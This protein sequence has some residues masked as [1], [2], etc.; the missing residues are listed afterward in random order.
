MSKKNLQSIKRQLREKYRKKHLS[1]TMIDRMYAHQKIAGHLYKL[2]EYRRNNTVLLYVSKSI[3]VD[4]Y[5]LIEKALKDGKTVAVPRCM[6]GTRNMAFYCI[7]SLNDLEK[8]NF[9][10]YEPKV[11]ICVPL[12]DMKQGLCIVP[13]MVFDI[14]G[15]RLGYGKGY[16]DR[17]LSVFQGNVVGLCYSNCICWQLPR[18]IYDKSVDILVT[19][20]FVWNTTKIP[21][22]KRG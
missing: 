10:V 3:E 17:F 9:G 13:G 20:K 1:M 7:T 5:A 12:N 16:Y 21:F 4:T 22:Q 18:G 6:E 15:Y 8:G 14:K 2:P 11:D 19:E